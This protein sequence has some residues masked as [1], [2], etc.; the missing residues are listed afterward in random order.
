MQFGIDWP[1]LVRTVFSP[2]GAF[3]LSLAVLV[4]GAI[5]GYLVW[6]SLRQFMRELGV[7]DAVEGTPFERTARGLGTSTVGIVSNLAALFVYIT[8]ITVALNIAQLVDPE[9]YWTRFT[10]FL[11]DLFIAAFALIIGLIAGDK[12]KLIVSER[13]RSVKLPEATVVPELV[14][15]SIFYLAVLIALGQLGVDTLALLILLAAYAFG[16]VFLVGLALRDVLAASAAGVYVLL[17]QP[18]SIGDEIAIGD[19]QGIVQEVDMF[20]THVES[21]GREH[22]IPNQKV[23]REGV[24]RIRD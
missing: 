11:P 23:F 4:V 20:V 5:F 2:E 24:V 19:R 22:V 14:K 17:T 6:R 7:P 21:D 3:V 10:A 12:A 13:L 15:Y 1:E 9:A 18:Y 16:L 8:A